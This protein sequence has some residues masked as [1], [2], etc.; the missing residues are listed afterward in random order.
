MPNS[1]CNKI[2][3]VSRNFLWGASDGN[4]RMPLSNW[5]NICR[6]K[7]ASGLGL[8]HAK[9]SNLAFLAKLGWGLVH[10]REELWVQVLRNRYGC[11]DYLIPN[12][13]MRQECSNVWRGICEA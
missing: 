10:N 3:G 7:G 9:L 8:R 4:R 13:S 2:D 5:D 1:I 11:G 12:V 6:P